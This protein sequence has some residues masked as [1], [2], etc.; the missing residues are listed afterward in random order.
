MRGGVRPLFSLP[1]PHG[2]QVGEGFS[3]SGSESWSGLREMTPHVAS[4]DM[5]R[6]GWASSQARDGEPFSSVG[7]TM[8]GRGPGVKN[9]TKMSA[10]MSSS[11]PAR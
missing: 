2:R 1:R 8:G 11:V 9:V 7:D 5:M 4:A 6:L 3:D 10:M